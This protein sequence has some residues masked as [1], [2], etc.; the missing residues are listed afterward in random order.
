[1][2]PAGLMLLHDN[3]TVT[4][5]IRHTHDT[6]HHNTT[7]MDGSGENIKHPDSWGKYQRLAFS[8]GSQVKNGY[9]A[10]LDVDKLFETFEFV[11][12]CD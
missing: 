11:S 4:H 1:M 9:L 3:E 6:L 7:L 5:N 2:Y 12:S 10:V 8:F